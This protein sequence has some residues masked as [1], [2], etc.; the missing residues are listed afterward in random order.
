MT[1]FIEKTPIKKLGQFTI[2][3]FDFVLK[4]KE[5][6]RG[7]RT[8]VRKFYFKNKTYLAAGAAASA[9]A[10]ASVMLASGATGAAA[11]AVTFSSA[12]GAAASSVFADSLH[13]INIAAKS[14]ADTI[15]IMVRLLKKIWRKYTTTHPIF[16]KCFRLI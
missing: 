3:L 9:V 16:V 11:S 6:R 12:T 8:E 1:S 13:P 5:K 7:F 4:C 15:F 14:N 2:F 10:F